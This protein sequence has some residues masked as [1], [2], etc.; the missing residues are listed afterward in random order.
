MKMIKFVA[1]GFALT[2]LVNCNSAKNETTPVAAP[3]CTIKDEALS[4]TSTDTKMTW[5]E[6]LLVN[7]AAV[8]RAALTKRTTTAAHNLVTALNATELTQLEG[9]KQRLIS[10]DPKVLVV[11]QN[12]LFRQAITRAGYKILFQRDWPNDMELN[13]VVEKNGEQYYGDFS[14]RGI[15]LNPTK[16]AKVVPYPPSQYSVANLMPLIPADKKYWPNLTEVKVV[17]LDTPMDFSVYVHQIEGIRNPRFYLQ[18]VGNAPSLMEPYYDY[19]KKSFP[20]ES[21]EFKNLS[22]AEIKKAVTMPICN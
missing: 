16:D 15:S 11:E 19:I 14:Y 12:N 2:T 7:I 3:Q 9:M 8:K 17:T 10:E 21:P 22:E 1:L 13:A 6:L 20:G 4:F 5:D 18:V